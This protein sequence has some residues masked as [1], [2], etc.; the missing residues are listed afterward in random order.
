MITLL[1]KFPQS[2]IGQPVFGEYMGKSLQ[3]T[4]WPILYTRSF[5]LQHT[6]ID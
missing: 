1:Q 5:L 2:V 3:L 4:F 6:E